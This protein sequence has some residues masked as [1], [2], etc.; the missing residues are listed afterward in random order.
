MKTVV[1][2]N[3][4]K[5]HETV[6]MIWGQGHGCCGW[7][8]GVVGLADVPAYALAIYVDWDVRGVCQ[9]L[10]YAARK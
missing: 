3:Y 10:M 9:Y 1:P 6:N 8:L 4:D 2:G 5:L 7:I